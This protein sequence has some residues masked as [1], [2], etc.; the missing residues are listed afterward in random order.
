[1]KKRIIEKILYVLSMTGMNKKARYTYHKSLLAGVFMFA[2]LFSAGVAHAALSAMGPINAADGFPLWYQ[3]S[4]GLALE[5][6]LGVN[7]DGTGPVDP[8]CVVFN[9]AG[10]PIVGDISFPTNFPPEAFYAVA[11]AIAKLGPNGT[12][13]TFRAALEGSFSNANADPVAGDQIIFLRINFRIPHPS[14]LTPNAS[15]TSF[16]HTDNSALLPM[17]PATLKL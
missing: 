16:I 11:D 15:Y 9:A 5:Q 6:C 12:K 4:T 1:M 14:R 3:D 2:F 8:N 7:P 13:A 17:Q 10:G